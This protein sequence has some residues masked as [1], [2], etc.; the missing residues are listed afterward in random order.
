MGHTCAFQC[1]FG[2]WKLSVPAFEHDIVVYKYNAGSFDLPSN[3][4]TTMSIEHLYNGLYTIQ[5]TY[6]FQEYLAFSDG[7]LNY[8]RLVDDASEEDAL[9]V[10][11]SHCCEQ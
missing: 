3:S 7:P 4:R 1:P 5:S 6:H 11:P 8:A 2:L 9:H 10:C